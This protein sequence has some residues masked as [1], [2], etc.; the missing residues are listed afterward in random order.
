MWKWKE[1]SGGNIKRQMVRIGDSCDWSRERFTLDASLSRAVREVFVTLYEKK[2]I[3]RGSYI[4]QWC[5]RCQTALSDLEVNHDQRNGGLWHIKYPVVGSP[6][7]YV[8]VATTRPETMLGDSAVAVNPADE[9][10]LKYHGR[11]SR[12]R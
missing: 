7:E 4:I 5:P 6:D 1:E 3:Y 10:Y 11:K 12:C 2:L 9:R 8:V